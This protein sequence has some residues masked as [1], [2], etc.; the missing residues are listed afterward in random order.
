MGPAFKESGWAP[1]AADEVAFL[2]AAKSLGMT[3][4][5]FFSWDDSRANLPDVWKAIAGYSWP[6]TTT[7][8]TTE[9]MTATII[10]ALNTHNLD[11][12]MALYTDAS[13][14]IDSQSTIQ[15]TSAIRSWYSDLLTNKIPSATFKLGHNT[16]S[17][18][19]RHFNWTATSTN[20][21]VTDGTDTLGLV[22]GKIAYHYSFFNITS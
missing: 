15:G 17:G 22:N 11:T 9:D 14:H 1:T 18:T 6:Y 12:I 21:K 4:A 13:V 3:A 10:K 19:T 20:G 2:N 8:T 5:N 16:I 7:T